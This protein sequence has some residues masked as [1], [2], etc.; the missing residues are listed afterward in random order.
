MELTFDLHTSDGLSN[1]EK[2][3][4]LRRLDSKLSKEG[5]ILLQCDESRSQHKN[6]D[7]VIERFFALLEAALTIRKKR[8]A[9]KPSKSAVEKRLK[10]K[11]IASLKKANRSKP[12]L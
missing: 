6:K 3:R 5:T 8:K 10:G 9:T 1:P 7:L 11:K 4:L 12:E 2:E